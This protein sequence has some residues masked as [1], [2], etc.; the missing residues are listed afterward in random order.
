VRL[1]GTAMVAVRQIGL[2]SGAGSPSE[3]IDLK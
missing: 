1:A 3:I 2:V